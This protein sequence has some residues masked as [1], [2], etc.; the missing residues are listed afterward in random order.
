MEQRFSDVNG[1]IDYQEVLSLYQELY[2]EAEVIYEKASAPFAT[3]RYLGTIGNG[4]IHPEV[5]AIL[6]LH[7]EATRALS[8]AELTLA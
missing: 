5:R 7:D 2:E 4:F 3:C 6:D 8:D 1:E